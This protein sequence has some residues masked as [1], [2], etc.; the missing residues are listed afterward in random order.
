ML[1]RS[2]VRMAP[3]SE[4]TSTGTSMR[5]PSALGMDSFAIGTISCTMPAAKNTAATAPMSA[6]SMFSPTS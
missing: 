6:N 5:I 1:K 4:K 3:I 2:E